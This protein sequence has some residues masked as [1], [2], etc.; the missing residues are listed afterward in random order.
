VVEVRLAEPARAARVAPDRP[1]QPA[2]ALGG[3]GL[4]GRLAAAVGGPQIV[5]DALVRGDRR[6]R[7]GEAQGREGLA[8]GVALGPVEVEQGVVD[9]EE[10]GAEAGQTATWRGR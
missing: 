8:Q 9:V 1:Q 6:R 10:N 3:E 4:L 5:V 2:E 7:A